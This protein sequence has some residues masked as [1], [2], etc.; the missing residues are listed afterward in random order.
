MS[1]EMDLETYPVSAYKQ[2][3]AL[4]SKIAALFLPA[5]GGAASL[6][7]S[8]FFPAIGKAQIEWFEFVG[9]KVGELIRR[10]DE[11]EIHQDMQEIRQ[12]TQ[13]GQQA[14]LAQAFEEFDQRPEFLAVILSTMDIALRDEKRKKWEPLRN[15]VLNTMRPNPPNDT[16]RLMFRNNMAAF[17]DWHLYLLK[18]FDT[19][20]GWHLNINGGEVGQSHRTVEPYDMIEHDIPELAMERELCEQCVAQLVAAGLMSLEADKLSAEDP[21]FPPLPLA[22]FDR[23][24]RGPRPQTFRLTTPLGQQFL[25]FIASP[26]A[27][28]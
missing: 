3:L 10:A 1:E 2:T 12:D 6:L 20:R 18:Y 21:N 25:R 5:G 9:A 28:A 15:I 26:G 14:A 24:G 8:I 11:L 23:L 22:F 7:L 4:A 13:E 27:E 17:G 19:S 16:L